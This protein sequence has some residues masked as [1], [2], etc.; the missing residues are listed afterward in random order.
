MKMKG[1]R[2]LYSK[3]DNEKRKGMTRREKKGGDTKRENGGK[4][5]DDEPGL[6]SRY[7]DWLRAGRPRSQSSS[8][9]RAKNFHHV[10]TGSDVH[11][12]SYPL[13]TGDNAAGT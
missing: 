13:D 12:T 8:P 9:G 11:P 7:S 3:S 4:S 10:H 1:K 5:E 2:E 6:R